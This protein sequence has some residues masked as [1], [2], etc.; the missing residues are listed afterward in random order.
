MRAPFGNSQIVAR[1]I[2]GHFRPGRD[3]IVQPRQ[4]GKVARALWPEKTVF[5]VAEI[6]GCEERQAKRYLSG[7]Y[8]V[9]YIMLRRVNDLMQGITD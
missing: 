2:Q 4:F 9:P 6:C 1:E 5:H 8:P 3:K 7:E